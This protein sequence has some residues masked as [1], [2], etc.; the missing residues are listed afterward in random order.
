M[1]EKKNRICKNKEFDRVFTG[2]SFYAK[3]L[4][5]KVGDSRFSETRIG[6]LVGLKVSKKAVIRNKLKRQIRSIISQELPLLKD[7]K[8]LVV[9]TLPSI[10]DVDFKELQ[11]ALKTG[12]KKLKLYK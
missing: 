5:L 11:D 12:L 1:L 8:D 9:I 7:G 4:G 3:F 10:I 6:V 2:Q